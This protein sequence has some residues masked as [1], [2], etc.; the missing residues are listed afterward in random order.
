[1]NNDIANGGGTHTRTYQ[2]DASHTETGDCSGDTYCLGC[3]DGRLGPRGQATR[4]QVTQMLKSFIE[5][6]E[7]T[8]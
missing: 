4:A 5:N 1:M 6:Q 7:E 8:T 3:G 2:R